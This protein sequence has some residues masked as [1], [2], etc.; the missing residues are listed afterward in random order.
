MTPRSERATSRKN[1]PTPPA[2]LTAPAACC[3]PTTPTRAPPLPNS[4]RML[5]MGL[6]GGATVVVDGVDDDGAE[7]AVGG[8]G[9]LGVAAGGERV[10]AGARAP[11]LAWPPGVQP[12]SMGR[13]TV[14]PSPMFP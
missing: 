4:R 3:G 11:A 6:G 12:T 1:P 9:V 5:S 10:A 2:A 8:A 14:N 7:L 13:H